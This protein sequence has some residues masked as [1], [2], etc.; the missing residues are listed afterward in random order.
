[1]SV[2]GNADQP[3]HIKRSS[4]A[5]NI[6]ALYALQAANYLIPLLTLPYLIRVLGAHHYGIMAMAYATV[7]FLVLF[8]DAGY[9]TR[10]VRLLSR[11]DLTHRDI[12]TLFAT[13]VW[14]K[15]IQTLIAFGL[16]VAAVAY[17]PAVREHANVYLVTFGI[18]LGSLLFPTW[19]FQGLQIMH[20]T[21]VC[22]V[23][24]RVLATAGIFLLVKSP[25]D[26]VIAAAL[27]SSATLLSGL[28]SLPIVF[29]KLGLSL[30]LPLSTLGKS[31][32]STVRNGFSLCFSEY[33]VNATNNAGVFILGLFANETAV[34]IFA[35]VSKIAQAVANAFQPLLRA[36]FPIIANLSA[37]DPA[38]ATAKSKTWTL[39]IISSAAVMA[40]GL[41]V[42]SSF[43]LVLLFGP[44]WHSHGRALQGLAIWVFLFVCASA[45]GQ[46]SLLARGHQSV[47]AYCLLAGGLIQVALC[48]YGAFQWGVIGVVAALIASEFCRLVAF[49]YAKHRVVNG[50]QHEN[51]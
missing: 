23:G 24:G 45:V 18:V 34:G 5:S 22:S 48:V 3:A 7:F 9:N 31:L 42:L 43:V 51:T 35:A 6:T 12:S 40:T 21:T 13:N 38:S 28:L 14:L 32:R 29:K 27:Q 20:Y 26:L 33:L 10:A 16:L 49:L 19:L 1:M 30:W 25:S 47:Y 17:V 39:R 11:E 8:I 4:L 41:I 46:F 15:V 36:V 37:T 44:E 50:I 2:A